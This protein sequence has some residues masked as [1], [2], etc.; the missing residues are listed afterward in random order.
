MGIFFLHFELLNF[1]YCPHGLSQ[2]L[3][4]CKI[5]LML[6]VICRIWNLVYLQ[7]VYIQLV[8]VKTVDWSL[9]VFFQSRLPS[10][11]YSCGAWSLWCL[12]IPWGS[13][14]SCSSSNT[15]GLP[16]DLLTS[17]FA[18]SLMELLNHHGVDVSLGL[19]MWRVAFHNSLVL[20]FPTAYI[21]SI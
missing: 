17:E 21:K 4:L 1:E 14:L 3:E 18:A 7:R 19:A 15:C 2:Y 13:A 8:S 5:I 10:V 12:S 16:D 9:L 11:C 20:L 6:R